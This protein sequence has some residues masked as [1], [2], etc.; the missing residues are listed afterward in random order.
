LQW[1]KIWQSNTDKIKNPDII[2]TGQVLTIPPAGPKSTDEMKAER[3]YWR[4]KRAA[5][6]QQTPEQQ[7]K[8]QKG[9]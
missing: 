9:Q 1:P 4:H 8:S 2:R 6:E 5:I 3:K 7:E